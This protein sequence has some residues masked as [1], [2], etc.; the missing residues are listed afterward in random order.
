MGCR[1]PILLIWVK[2]NG[3]TDIQEII[4]LVMIYAQII[5]LSC[6]QKF[7]FKCFATFCVE[8]SSHPTLEEQ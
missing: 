6:I 8:I 3:G 4:S 7:F 2:L 1:C 5:L